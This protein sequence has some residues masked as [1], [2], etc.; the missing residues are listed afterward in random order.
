MERLPRKLGMCL[1]PLL[2]SLLTLA[3]DLQ[4]GDNWLAKSLGDLQGMWEK[5][6]VNQFE[7]S[8]L[9]LVERTDFLKVPTEMRQMDQARE[10]WGPL[11]TTLLKIHAKKGDLKEVLEGL[12]K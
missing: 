9:S 7:V 8:L 1:G 10:D 5:A 12:E 2:C 3:D 4:P 11:I 6:I